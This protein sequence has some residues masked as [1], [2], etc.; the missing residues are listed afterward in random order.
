MVR[1]S[2]ICLI[3]RSTKM[4][5]WVYESLYEFTPMLRSGEA[6]FYF[7][8]N[9]P[10]D[11][12]L[13]HLRNK[14]YNFIL[15]RND[16]YTDEQLFNIGYSYPEY[17]NRVY[18][19]Y[20]Q[21]ILH[22]RGDIVVLINSDNYFSP[23]WLE[24]LLKYAD[25]KRIVTSQLVEPKHVKY[26]IFQSALHGEFGNHPDNFMKQDFLKFANTW[27]ITGIALGGAYMP[28]LFYKDLAIYSGLYPEGNIA[29]KSF[30]DIKETGDKAFF[31]KFGRLGAQHIT[32][33]DSIVYHLKEGEKDDNSIN[34]IDND[35]SSNNLESIITKKIELPSLSIEHINK[36]LQPTEDHEY[37][38]NMLINKKKSI[39]NKKRPK[40]KMKEKIF[41]LLKKVL[42]NFIFKFVYKIW[43]TLKSYF[44]K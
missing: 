25:Y 5:D 22:A 41:L 6:E 26:E 43:C 15:N 18:K 39:L 40:L 37:F 20:N 27:R 1:I 34:D 36:F 14:G 4:A 35:L 31:T 28:C 9:D 21:G 38:I 3:Y 33:K 8:A 10:T 19:G 7:V 42:P 13:E 12:L 32:A 17:M 30:G 29:G 44:K 23:D 11:K 24:N 2:I 16:F